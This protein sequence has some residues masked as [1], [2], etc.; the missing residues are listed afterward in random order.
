MSAPRGR[1]EA[2]V[3]SPGEAVKRRRVA[4]GMDIAQLA[5]RAGVSRTTIYD[6]EAGRTEPRASSV[7]KIQRALTVA[8][9]APVTSASPDRGAPMTE[10]TVEK[11]HQ[12]I[13]FVSVMEAARMLNLS[14]SGIHAL[15]DKGEID[16]R[17]IGK[18]RVVFLASIHEWVKGL[19]KD[20]PKSRR[21]ASITP[22]EEL[23]EKPHL[24]V[25]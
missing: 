16:S 18:R 23:G 3:L 13:I 6:F 17:Y 15:L 7:A 21:L 19:P 24:N 5:R 12:P 14:K 1:R 4:V 25:R 2:G 10:H 11:G 9:S 8:E 22:P 20:P